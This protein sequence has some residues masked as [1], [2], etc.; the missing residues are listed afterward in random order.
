MCN[1]PRKMIDPVKCEMVS[2]IVG[3]ILEDGWNSALSFTVKGVK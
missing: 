3:Q 2:K 1:F